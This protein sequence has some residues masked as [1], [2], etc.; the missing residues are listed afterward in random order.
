MQGNKWDYFS[1]LTMIREDNW[2]GL[3]CDLPLHSYCWAFPTTWNWM[4]LFL[5]WR[6]LFLLNSYATLAVEKNKRV[7]GS[8]R[9]VCEIHWLKV[10]CGM[11]S[12]N[13]LFTETANAGVAI[14][15]HWDYALIL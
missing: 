1:L 13:F 5:F 15:A 11:F 10:E 9:A 8:T 3:W 6:F 14:R 7:D 2:Y 4:S 12:M